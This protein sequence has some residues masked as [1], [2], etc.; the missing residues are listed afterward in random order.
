[1]QSQ[2]VETSMVPVLGAQKRKKEGARERHL[3]RKHLNRG[4]SRTGRGMLNSWG[5]KKLRPG[6]KT[7]WTLVLGRE[8]VSGGGGGERRAERDRPSGPRKIGKKKTKKKGGLKRVDRRE[9]QFPFFVYQIFLVC[10]KGG[11]KEKQG[12]KL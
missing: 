8:G 2:T 7:K 12:G 5:Q 10:G 11:R 1:M 4:A 3:E 6:G 9:R